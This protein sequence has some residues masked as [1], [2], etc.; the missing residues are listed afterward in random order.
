MDECI[1]CGS[2]N[3]RKCVELVGGHLEEEEACDDCFDS[4]Y[5]KISLWSFVKRKLRKFFKQN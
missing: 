5:I 4:T 2:T 3:V 1:Y